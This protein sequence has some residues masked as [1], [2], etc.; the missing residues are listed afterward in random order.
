MGDYINYKQTEFNKALLQYDIGD[1]IEIYVNVKLVAQ[2]E[3]TGVMRGVL[4][5]HVDDSLAIMEP[6]GCTAHVPWMFKSEQINYINTTRMVLVEKFQGRKYFGL[7]PRFM[8]GSYNN[9][10]KKRTEFIRNYRGD[11]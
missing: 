6:S 7:R 9:F 1:T 3:E 8:L 2:K 11:L 10:V 4:W 5:T